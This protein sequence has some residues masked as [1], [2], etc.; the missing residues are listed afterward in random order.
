[1]KIVRRNILTNKCS[2]LLK[3]YESTKIRK[4]QHNAFKSKLL[5]KVNN[6]L[7]NL[8]KTNQNFA[9]V[10]TANLTMTFGTICSFSPPL[11][12][13]ERYPRYYAL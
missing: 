7:P 9:V 2:D 10:A 4:N 11:K 3:F 5:Y 13:E 12:N 8:E 1:M 6:G